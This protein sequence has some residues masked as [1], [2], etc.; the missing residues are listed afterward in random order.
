MPPLFLVMLGGA[1]GA[2][3]RYHIGTVALRNLGPGF[4]F[5]TWIVNLLGGL[6]MGVLAG[7]I[8]RTPLEGEPLRLFLGV[9]VLGGFTTFS[10]FSLESFD[11]L[12]RGEYMMATAY[13]V[14]SVAGSILMLFFGLALGRAVA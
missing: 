13:A 7:V 3:F 2:G 8:A 6:L 4:P 1:I 12:S 11:M 5:G 14:S 10:A 9:G